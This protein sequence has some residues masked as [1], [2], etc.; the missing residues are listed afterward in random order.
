MERIPVQSSN[1]AFIAYDADTEI[2]EIEFTNST[3]YEYKNVPKV[4]Y[5][6]LMASSSHGTY[7]NKNIRNFYPCQKIG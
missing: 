7:F 6:E 5:D 3:L 4:V 2:L 1:L